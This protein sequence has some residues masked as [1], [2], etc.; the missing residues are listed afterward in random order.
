VAWGAE[1]PVDFAAACAVSV[2]VTDILSSEKIA[3]MNPMTATRK[4][5]AT[6]NRFDRS[7]KTEKI[8]H[9]EHTAARTG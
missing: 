6:Y 2:L 4:T 1:K 3:L 8:N 5:P 9:A 7:Q